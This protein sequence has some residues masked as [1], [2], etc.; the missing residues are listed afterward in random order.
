MY[1]Y[2]KERYT[3]KA[4]DRQA[5][6]VSQ[7]YSTKMADNGSLQSHLETML[8]MRKQLQLSNSN[9]TDTMFLKAL[10]KSLAPRFLN[11]KDSLRSRSLTVQEVISALTTYDDELPKET[12]GRPRTLWKRMQEILEIFSPN[13][14]RKLKENGL[15]DART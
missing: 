6:L 13:F 8:L 15:P 12:R 14:L 2:L 7:L 5:E 1:G 10:Y 11:Y 4:E 9:V 3:A